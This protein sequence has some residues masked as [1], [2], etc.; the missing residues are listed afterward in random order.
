[1]KDRQIIHR[2]QQ[3]C[4]ESLPP[5]VFEM[6]Q[7]VSIGLHRS[8]KS[9]DTWRAPWFGRGKQIK[10]YLFTRH[11]AYDPSGAGA[12]MYKYQWQRIPKGYEWI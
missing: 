11:T 7:K 1:M 8:R 9:L 5:D 4:E 3:M 12:V 10:L 6:W 2:M